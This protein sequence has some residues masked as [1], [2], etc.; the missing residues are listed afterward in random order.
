M[1][2]LDF[3]SNITP[4]QLLNYIVQLGGSIANDNPHIII[5]RT[6]LEE[7][8]EFTRNTINRCLSH[9]L[10]AEIQFARAASEYHITIKGWEYLRSLRKLNGRSNGSARNQIMCLPG[11]RFSNF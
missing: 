9:G 7:S 10:L 1:I 3:Q 8:S 6:C 11:T 4:E 5:P 2:S